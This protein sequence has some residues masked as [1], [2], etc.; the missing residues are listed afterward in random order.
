MSKDHSIVGVSDAASTTTIYL[1]LDN[2]SLS[3][4]GV[5]FHR[6]FA[7]CNTVVNY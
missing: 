3:I 4:L 2:G 5:R 1:N 6:H 7:F